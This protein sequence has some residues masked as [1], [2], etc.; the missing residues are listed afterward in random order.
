MRIKVDGHEYLAHR[1][2]WLYQEGKWPA[3]QI[4]HVN[5][6]TWD[7]RWANLREANS[8]QNG[9]NR[10]LN[11]NSTSGF[12]GVTWCKRRRCW[13]ADIKIRGRNVWLGY[14]DTAEQAA[15]A[16]IRAQQQIFDF[17]P[18]PRTQVQQDQLLNI[19]RAA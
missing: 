2:A 6:L 10:A 11:R 16:R 12:I 14:F 9:Q 18:V 19:T 15:D 8:Q 3:D 5:G 7:N 1:L 4:D 13:Q 17:Q